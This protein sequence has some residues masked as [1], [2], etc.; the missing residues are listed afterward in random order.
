M[1]FVTFAAALLV[2]APAA[3]A[4]SS[5]AAVAASKSNTAAIQPGMY[6]IE[7]AIGG[8]TLNGTLEL[9]QVGDSLAPTIRVGDHPPPPIKS[10]M[11]NGSALDIAAGDAGTNV[12]YKL[13][14]NGETLSGTFTFNGDPGFVT[15]KRRK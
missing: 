12:A 7:L 8:G 1:R 3:F 5:G 9:K 15:G 2:V 6:D 4:Q 13:K 10:V 11:R 14:F